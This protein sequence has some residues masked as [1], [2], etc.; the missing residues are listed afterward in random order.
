MTIN[1]DASRLKTDVDFARQGRQTGDFRLRPSDNSKALGYHPVPVFCLQNG[2]GPTLVVTGGTHGDEFEGPAAILRLMH[3]LDLEKLN[4]RLIMF[5]ALNAPAVKASLRCSPLDDGNLNRAFPGDADGSPTEQI[6]YLIEHCILPGADAAIDIHSGGRASEFVPL[7]MYVPSTGELGERNR[8]LADAFRAPYCWVMGVGNDNRT[9]NSAAERQGVPMFATELGGGGNV[10]TEYV[11]LA[12]DGI[13]RVLQSLGMWQAPLVAATQATTY[14][15]IPAT[16]F[17]LFAPRDGLFVP[18]KTPG[19]R[20]S[21][22]E[23]VGD[24][25]SIFEPEREPCTLVAPHSSLM[26]SQTR[27]GQ[28]E[29]GDFL[30]QLSDEIS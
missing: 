22:G 26:I 9:V 8:A 21:K 29:R 15:R 20:F 11:R 23:A 3:R 7:S 6:A 28:V 19:S 18:A 24:I 13:L 1:L 30:M 2:E 10:N 12:C 17:T 5:P 16:D 25:Y 14:F 4:G 27:Y